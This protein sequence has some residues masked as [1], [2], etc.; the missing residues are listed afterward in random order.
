[1]SLKII[2]GDKVMIITGKDKG[3]LGKVT[4]VILKKNLVVVSGLNK[5]KK[6]KKPSKDGGGAIINQEAPLHI[7]NVMLVDDSDTPSKVGYKFEDDKKKRFFKKTAS[8]V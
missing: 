5:V 3:K 4:K 2:K 6:H 7:S 1:M 8:N